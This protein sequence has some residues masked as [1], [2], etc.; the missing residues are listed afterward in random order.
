MYIRLWVS[1][2]WLQIILWWPW[3]SQ[4]YFILSNNKWI[5]KYSEPL[6]HPCLLE[7]HL[8]SLQFTYI[9]SPALISIRVHIFSCYI[10]L[11]SYSCSHI[12]LRYIYVL[13]FIFISVHTNPF[14][15]L[16]CI[17]VHM[18]VHFFSTFQILVYFSPHTSLLISQLSYLSLSTQLSPVLTSQFTYI[19]VCISI[20]IH[21]YLFCWHIYLNSH[22]SLF[23]F[24]YLYQFTS[25]FKFPY[26]HQFLNIS[27]SIYYSSHILYISS[28]IP[29]SIW[30]HIHFFPSFYIY[31]SS[32]VPW[33]PW[34]KAVDM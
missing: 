21:I 20:S 11:S 26:V 25:L 6:R 23:Q 17:S 28:P 5:P 18:H 34:K 1:S 10:Y 13:V 8:S 14:Y 9:S 27:I 33:S 3:F 31:S 19:S 4:F 15:S 29:M 16:I 7:I 12:Y 24:S 22:I 30:F 32:K 2:W